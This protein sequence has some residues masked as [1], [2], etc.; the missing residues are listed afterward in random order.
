MTQMIP[1]GK[2]EIASPKAFDG[3]TRPVDITAT[4]SFGVSSS[5]TD[6]VTVGPASVPG[7]FQV[8]AIGPGTAQITYTLRIHRARQVRSIQSIRPIRP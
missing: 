8:N 4:G 3:A 5:N 1:I 7:T 6:A 2:H